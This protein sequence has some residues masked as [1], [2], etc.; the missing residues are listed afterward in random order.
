MNFLGMCKN[1]VCRFFLRFAAE[2]QSIF[3]FPLFAQ[4][5]T[6]VG[7]IC[8]TLFEMSLVSNS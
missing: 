5:L 1:S 6:A 7:T 4:F 2:V 8:M 3:S